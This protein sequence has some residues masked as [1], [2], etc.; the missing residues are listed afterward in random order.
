VKKRAIEVIKIED[1]A[2][3]GVSE[4]S[5]HAETVSVSSLSDDT[6]TF[7]ISQIVKKKKNRRPAHMIQKDFKC[8][9]KGCN[10]QYR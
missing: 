6:K 9:L 5:E 10:K 3:T 8:P 2:S 1:D 7:D 4:S